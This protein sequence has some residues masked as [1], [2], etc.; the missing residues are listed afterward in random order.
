MQGKIAF[1]E[2]MAIPETTEQTRVFAGES[3]DFDAFTR[4]ILDLDDQRLGSMDACGIELAI[5][6]LNAPAVQAILD[7]EEA[8]DTARQANDA[9]KAAIDRHPTRYAGL[10][11]V[12]LQDP[13]AASAELERCVN[14]LGFKGVLVN[15]FTQ[16]AEENNALYYDLPEFREFWQTVADLDVP[17]YLHPRMNIPSQSKNL[18]G[19]PWLRS[20]PWGFSVETATHALRLCG[21]SLFEDFPNLRLI[22]GHL[23]EFIPY[24]LW[25]MDARMAFSSRGYRGKKPLGE[26]FKKHFH[27]TTSGNFSDPTFRCALEVI[28]EERICFCADYPFERMEDAATWFDNTQ[29]IDD[30]QR[31]RIGRNNAIDLFGL[32]LPKA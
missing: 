5:L 17:F 9:I 32:D 15:G 20:S 3:A 18:D 6:S 21:S 11:A 27:I 25:R 10:A 13:A 8:I 26:Y 14:Q 4:D 30:Q 16:R 2:H 7:P 12:A 29:V 24:N 19:H 22:I 31:S 23:G 28:G 1:E